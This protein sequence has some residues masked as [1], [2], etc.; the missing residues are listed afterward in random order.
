LELKRSFA[1]GQIA[2]YVGEGAGHSD[3]S[4]TAGYEAAIKSFLNRHLNKG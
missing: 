3:S 2:L 4:R 1:P